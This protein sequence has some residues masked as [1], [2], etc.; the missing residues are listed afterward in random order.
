MKILIGLSVGALVG[1]GL[2]EAGAAT[3][4]GTALSVPNPETWV[5]LGAAATGG[6]L[7]FFKKM[8]K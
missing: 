8:E 7:A 4:V 6:L 5:G 2:V 1:L 3:A